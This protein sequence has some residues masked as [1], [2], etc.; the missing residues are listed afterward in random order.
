MESEGLAKKA[1][2]ISAKKSKK[3]NKPEPYLWDVKVEDQ[4]DD[5]IKNYSNIRYTLY[6]ALYN[7]SFPFLF[8]GGKYWNRK[9]PVFV[10]K[11]KQCEFS[12]LEARRQTRAPK[13]CLYPNILKMI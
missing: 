2:L 5:K 1:S 6:T 9:D 7:L 13:E 11:I 10:I 4:E 12:A 3:R 8:S